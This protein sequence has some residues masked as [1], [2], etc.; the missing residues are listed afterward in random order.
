[1]V[2]RPVC[3]PLVVLVL[4]PRNTLLT[5]PVYTDML[6]V[7]A[8]APAAVIAAAAQEREKHMTYEVI[9]RYAHGTRAVIVQAA[10]AQAAIR[11]ARPMLR[12]MVPS[13]Y[14]LA[15]VWAVAA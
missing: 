13:V 10:D 3:P 6:A 14:P 11:R 8:R 2:L 5:S 7:P 9:A 15:R 4:A 1:M 12:R